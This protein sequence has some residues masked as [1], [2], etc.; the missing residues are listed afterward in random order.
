MAFPDVLPINDLAEEPLVVRLDTPTVELHRASK[1]LAQSASSTAI[2][3]DNLALALKNRYVFAHSI[4]LFLGW[5]TYVD[6]ILLV[7]LHAHGNCIG[8]CF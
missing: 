2:G 3:V 1:F 6:Y 8:V 7:S 5:F 4:A